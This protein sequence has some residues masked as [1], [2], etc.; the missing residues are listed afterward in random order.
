VRVTATPFHVDG[1]PL[2][3][4][5]G[6]PYR[7]GEHTRRVLGDVLGYPPARIDEL[8]ATKVIVAH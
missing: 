5:A 8:A 6:A 7:I 3:P 1:A 2:A 4:S